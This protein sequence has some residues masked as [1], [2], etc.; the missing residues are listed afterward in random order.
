MT[1]FYYLTEGTT[2]RKELHGTTGVRALSGTWAFEKTVVKL[3]GYRLNFSCDQIGQRYSDFVLIID[4]TIAN[5]AANLYIDLYLHDKMVKASVSPCGL[6]ELDVQQV[7]S[8][9]WFVLCYVCFFFF[10][11]I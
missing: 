7:C 4:A 3:Q 9:L 1:I 6:L 8:N 5:E 10:A 11:F 2:N